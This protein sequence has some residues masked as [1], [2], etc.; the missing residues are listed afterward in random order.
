[1]TQPEPAADPWASRPL[2]EPTTM[3]R[4]AVRPRMLG[5]LVLL[6]LAAAVCGR[7]GAWQLDRA[8]VRGA[9]AEERRTERLEGAPAAALADVLRPQQ[10]FTGEMAGRKVAATGTYDAAGQ[11][12][13]T[14]RPHDGRT[15]YLVLTPLRTSGGAVLPV[16]RGWV[17]SPAEAGAPPAGQVDVTGFLEASEA[18]GEG[19]ADGRTDAISSA[20]LLNSWGGP[21]YTGYVQLASSSP[22]QDPDLDVVPPAD[23]PGT[24]L[25][26]QNLLYAAQWW[27]FGVFAI[28]L[29]LRVVRDEARGTRGAGRLPTDSPVA[30]ADAGPGRGPATAGAAD[31]AEPPSRVRSSAAG[32]TPGTA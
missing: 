30:A 32:G 2:R 23:R 4:A 17:A 3:L 21:I 9:A 24:G 14:H 28:V 18:A 13:V 1:M 31:A 29:W 10:S 7:L 25:N 12:L 22:A 6:L 11:L 15:G 26:L 8:H 27:V 5:V 16:V 19:T 20:E